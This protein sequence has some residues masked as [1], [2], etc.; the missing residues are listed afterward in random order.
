MPAT[1]L[2]LDRAAQEL[3]DH[4]SALL[5]IRIALF[6]ADGR[7]LAVGL[8]RGSCGFCQ[9]IR[10]QLGREADC[11]REDAFRFAQAL[12][13]SA[14]VRY[15]C[16]AGL[17]ESIVPLLV[18][19][20]HLGFAMIGQYRAPDAPVPDRLFAE[21]CGR[22]GDERLR[23][24]WAAVPGADPRHVH[25]LFVRLVDLLL[26]RRLVDAV[27]EPGVAAVLDR[28]RRRPGDPL[29]VRAAAAIAGTSPATLDR[30][31]RAAAGC[32][33]KALQVR[34]RLAA[35]DAVLERGGAVRD[36]A[37]AAGYDDAQYFSRLYRRHRGAPPSAARPPAR[38]GSAPSPPADRR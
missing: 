13:E 32:G 11:R 1:H 24:A 15:R 36:A 26:L 2:A 17:E 38:A 5:A 7:T 28:L 29:S 16:H 23:R 12:R 10:Q 18:D 3:L 9:L 30:R 21:W 6:D 4:F 33:L 8:G 20:L 37:A 35:A 19:G 27:R 25:G 14:P 31:L 22:H 34:L